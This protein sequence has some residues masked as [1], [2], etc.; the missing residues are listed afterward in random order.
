MFIIGEGGVV[1]ARLHTYFPY[2]RLK[3]MSQLKICLLLIENGS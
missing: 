2:N 3:F 1:I